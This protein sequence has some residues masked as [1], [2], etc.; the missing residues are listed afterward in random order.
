MEDNRTWDVSTDALVLRLGEPRTWAVADL[1]MGSWCGQS[2][3]AQLGRQLD[4][5]PGAAQL[6]PDVDWSQ[7]DPD[8]R[9]AEFIAR[10][11]DQEA[12]GDTVV[13]DAVTAARRVSIE[14]QRSTVSHCLVVLPSEPNGL[15]RHDRAFL[16]EL[17]RRLG[18]DVPVVTIDYGTRVA[19]SPS[20]HA[21]TA[22]PLAT[23]ALV[24][25][26]LDPGMTDAFADDAAV[27][28][29]IPIRG[30]LFM[31]PPELRLAATC[32]GPLD[33]DR[34]A[35]QMRGRPELAAYGQRRGNVYFVD[36]ALL[37]RQGWAE[38]ERHNEEVAIE[39]VAHAARCARNPVEKSICEAQLC[40]FAIALR[41]FDIPVGVATPPTAAP[42]ELRGFLHQCRGWG[43]VMSGEP[44]GAL[45]EL[46]LAAAYLATWRHRQEY[47]YLLNI[48]AL[49]TLR[50]GDPSAALVLEE[51]IARTLQ[52]AAEPDWHLR[53]VNEMNLARLHW[54]HQ[55]LGEARAHYSA[56]FET[57]RG[58]GSQCDVLHA[59]VCNAK[60]DSLDAGS[61]NASLSWLRAAVL[62]AS[63][64]LPHAIGSRV[65]AAIIGTGTLRG[66]VDPEQ[67]SSA[68]LEQLRGCGWPVRPS[69]PAET[70]LVDFGWL[71]PDGLEG[72]PVDLDDAVLVADRGWAI[73]AAPRRPEMP[74]NVRATLDD[75]RALLRR[76]LID[77]LSSLRPLPEWDATRMLLV[78]DRLRR[79]MAG[80]TAEAVESALRLGISRLIINGR[81]YR[82]DRT[83][84]REAERSLRVR[85][86]PAI[87]GY[88]S[89]ADG[90]G[91][92]TFRRYRPPLPLSD[93]EAA[94]LRVV[95]AS[96][97]V[98]LGDVA[99]RLPDIEPTETTRVLRRLETNRIVELAVDDGDCRRLLHDTASVCAVQ[100]MGQS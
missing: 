64:D 6:P 34:L 15:A 62:W 93:R 91:R 10:A 2:A 63:V 50:S 43:L 66:P 81:E 72:T 75:G 21:G 3:A 90:S 20:G 70:D 52:A 56:A 39:L 55:E 71:E 97:D 7:L 48:T 98:T 17:K 19:E 79:G 68:L 1:S 83:H 86:S 74:G 31:V 5:S 51:E 16:T 26:L 87:D 33:Y 92:V 80:R 60:L 96:S 14:L 9:Y 94:V 35:A 100:R 41:L 54:R 85:M 18:A 36:P 12:V 65:A 38:F 78:D 28:T 67:V 4:M 46:G 82:L 13:I 49:A 22:E 57:T 77:V 99:V 23:L 88:D 47:L 42:P 8:W 73:V 11:I 30:D 25:G 89:A 44:A 58:V 76:T 40:G 95:V 69:D 61:V 53:Y 24:P 32:A 59:E 37:C 29:L 45:A 84:A 27:S